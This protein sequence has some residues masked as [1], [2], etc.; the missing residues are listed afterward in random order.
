MAVIDQLPGVQ[1]RVKVE[2]DFAMEYFYD[3]HDVKAQDYHVVSYIES[4]PGRCFSICI[5]FDETFLR[6]RR[7]GYPM[8]A[9]IHVDGT[10]TN[11]RTYTQERILDWCR[12]EIKYAEDYDDNGTQYQRRFLFAQTVIGQ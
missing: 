8:A 1:V 10:L 9:H 7:R 2:S 3:D 5:D 11:R 4:K 12:D 6:N